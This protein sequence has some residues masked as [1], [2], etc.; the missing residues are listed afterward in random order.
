MSEYRFGSRSQGRLDT[1]HPDIRGILKTAIER[2]PFDFTVVC[3]ARDKAAQDE[4]FATGM[5]KK[6]WP[7]SKHNVVSDGLSLAVDVAPWIKG[8]IP[9]NDEGSF[10]VLAGC[11]LSAAKC[12]GVK[13]RYG[14]DWDRDGLTEDQSFMDL[15]HF[16]LVGG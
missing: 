8:T 4:A 10:Y 12:R 1:C 2:A 15:G 5:S 3:G 6:R 16:E 9:W 14:G 13:M 7:E 11:I